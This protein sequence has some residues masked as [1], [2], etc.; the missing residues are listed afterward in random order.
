MGFRQQGFSR[1]ASAALLGALLLFSACGG[2]EDSTELLDEK[3]ETVEVLYNKAFE[4]FNRQAFKASIEQFEEVERQ[5]PYSEWAA[6]AQIMAA[7]AAYRGG[8]FND[9]IVILDRFVK[10][11]PTHPSAAYAYYLTALVYYTQ[12][13][14]VGRDQKASEQAR[15]ALKDVIERFPDSDYARDAKVK[16][17]LTEDHLAGKEMEIGR[18]YLKR[19]DYGAAINRFKYVIDH[20]QTTSHTPEAL[21][22][23]VESYL[24]LGVSPEAKKYA[25]VLGYNYPGSDWY[26]YSYEMLHAST[27]SRSPITK[28]AKTTSIR[29]NVS[30]MRLISQ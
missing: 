25:A 1:V 14:D 30:P 4:T 3:N 13:S 16:Y 10:L 21:H 17:E 28:N 20:Y 24:R 22:R 26:K 9:A 6:R 11:H 7:Y 29:Q 12:I 2:S 8:Q 19:Q 18:Y 15:T 23:L 27:T 5:H